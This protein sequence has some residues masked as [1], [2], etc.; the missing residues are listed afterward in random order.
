MKQ[1]PKKVAGDKKPQMHLLPT[2][3]KIATVKVL[4]LG[5]KKYGEYNWR[6]SE[7]LKANTYIAAI[8]RHLDQFSDGEDLDEESQVSHLA[9]I[10]ATCS[11]LMDAAVCGKLIDDRYK[12]PETD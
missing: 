6:T 7:G 12:R 8:H 1:D 9:H 5:A 3:A 2:I 10:M 4:E 11:I